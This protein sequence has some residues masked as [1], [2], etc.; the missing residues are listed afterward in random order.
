MTQI[1]AFNFLRWIKK[2]GWELHTSER[3]WYRFDEDQL[4][5][6]PWPPRNHNTKTDNE[7]WNFY[8][9]SHH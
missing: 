7:L 8:L 2:Q 4:P 1:Q 9:Q 5:G 6:N 3:Y